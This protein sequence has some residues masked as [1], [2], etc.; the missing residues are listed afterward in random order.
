MASREAIWF[1]R[2]LGHTDTVLEGDS[3]ELIKALCT[4]KSSLAPHDVILEDVRL[5]TSCF[6]KI[7]YINVCRMGNRAAHHLALLIDESI[8]I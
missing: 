8:L 3:T 2:R 7:E 6:E 4:N 1:A 5:A